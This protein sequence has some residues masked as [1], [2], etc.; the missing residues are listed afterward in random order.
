MKK[1]I[2]YT[3]FAA[4]VV[5]AFSQC[6]NSS[7]PSVKKVAEA[8]L[9]THKEAVDSLMIDANMERK[10]LIFKELK[11]RDAIAVLTQN[12][13]SELLKQEYP[14]NGFYGDDHYRIEFVVQEVKRDEVDARLYHIKGKNRFKKT[15][16]P[17]VGTVRL[18]TISEMI[19]PNID[20]T[21]TGDLYFVKSYSVGGE[22][23]IREDSTMKSSGIFKGVVNLDFATKVDGLRELWFFS[24]ET[25]AKGGGIK[26]DGTWT[27]YSKDQTKP[28]MWAAD[29]FQF[30]NSILKNFSIGERDVE[31]SKEYRHLGWDNFWE[32]DE[33]WVD[34]KNK[35][36]EK[37]KM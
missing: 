30:A 5:F 20:T 23:D 2:S 11:G 15:I 22:F 25:A 32:N 14:A 35:Q 19:D 12:D 21:E 29:I 7:T 9:V 24:P 18:K 26:Y 27:S 10:P 36:T 17:F 4:T 34:S 31:I 8:K 1:F 16:T 37:E 6:K 33:W 3:L 28:V 13:M